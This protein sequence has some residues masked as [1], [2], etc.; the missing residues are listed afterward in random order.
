MKIVD[1][2]DN[3]HHKHRSLLRDRDPETYADRGVP[4]GPPNIEELDW[5]GIARDLNNELFNRGLFNWDDV[6]RDGNGLTGAILSA[7]R[8]RL[9]NLY[10]R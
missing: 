7:V 5:E 2:E 9:I 6:Q 1:W 4:V 10:R 8:I 3:K